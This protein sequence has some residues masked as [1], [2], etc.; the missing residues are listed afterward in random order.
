MLCSAK[1]VLV[2]NVALLGSC[3]GPNPTG[4]VRLARVQTPLKK[5]PVPVPT[6]GHKLKKSTCN[7]A[8]WYVEGY[9]NGD[10]SR[11]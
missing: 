7:M 9:V 5:A 2:V 3:E 6:R 1:F 8:S 11:K 4:T 10:F